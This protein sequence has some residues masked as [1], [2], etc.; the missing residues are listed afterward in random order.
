MPPEACSNIMREIRDCLVD[1]ERECVIEYV[2]Q[3]LSARCSATEVV[4]GPMS[5]AMNEIGRLYEEGE[6]FIAELI[7]AA[8]IFK[9]VMNILKPELEKE[10]L[11]LGSRPRRLKIVLGTVKGDVHDI[12]KTL[13]AVM[14]QAA[15][16]EVVDLGVD[17]DSGK[18]IAAVEKYRADV[19]GMSALL[20]STAAY[21][22][23]VINELERR[24]LRD[25]VYV[26]VGGA[27]VTP[28]FAKEIGADAWAK[29]AVEAVK[30]VNSIARRSRT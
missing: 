22:K 10:A 15:G 17:V 18:F 26:I 19:L 3:A 13:V 7:D 24:G 20:T 21:M 27:A 30:I 25:K 9:E 2:K 11:E 8:D 6:Y 29:D 1:L 14:L 4:L 16:H 23:E 5:E 28:E 12:G